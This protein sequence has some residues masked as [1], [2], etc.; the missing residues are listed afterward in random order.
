MGRGVE[1]QYVPA[2]VPEPGHFGPE[3]ADRLQ[4]LP[5]VAF[6][7]ARGVSAGNSLWLCPVA[8]AHLQVA[9]PAL[10]RRH[11]REYHSRYAGV[12]ADLYRVL[13]SAVGRRQGGR[14]CFGRYRHGH[15]LVCVPVRDL[16]CR[17]SID[18]QGPKRGCSL[19]GH[20]CLPDAAL[21]YDSADVPQCFA[22]ADQRVYLALQ[23][24]VAAC[25]RG[26]GRNRHERPYHRGHDGLH[27]TVRGC[28]PVLSG[29]HPAARSLGERS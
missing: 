25:R 9:H 3:P 18:P 15:E 5:Y 17:Y 1:L 4:G 8:Y 22:Y 21:R 13:R 28:R 29:H 16:P 23:G 7:R 2:P 19:S 14:L 20:E 26:C 10:P 24:Y 11:L 6:D 27:Y 12:P